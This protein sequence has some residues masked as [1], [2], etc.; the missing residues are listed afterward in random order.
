MQP[1]CRP[2]P[3]LVLLKFWD[4]LNIWKTIELISPCG[5]TINFLFYL[6]QAKSRWRWLWWKHWRSCQVRGTIQTDE[7]QFHAV[8]CYVISSHKNWPLGWHAMAA[9]HGRD[10]LRIWGYFL[11]LEGGE[12]MKN[13]RTH[14]SECNARSACT[15]RV[16]SGMDMQVLLRATSGKVC[17]FS[18]LLSFLCFWL[19]CF[20]ATH[21]RVKEDLYLQTP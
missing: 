19:F 17:R 1:A 4:R 8:F 18:F 13:S 9:L 21:Q 10:V 12:V 5:H 3:C 2:W 20:F 15:R 16:L 6:G 14:K 11:N 7:F